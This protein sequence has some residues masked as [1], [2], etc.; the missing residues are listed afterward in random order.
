MDDYEAA[1]FAQIKNWKN[2]RKRLAEEMKKQELEEEKEHPQARKATEEEVKDKKQKESAQA[3]GSFLTPLTNAIGE[4]R[5]LVESL[6]VVS[7][8]RVEECKHMMTWGKYQTE[9]LGDVLLKLNLLIRKISDYEIRFGTQY[10]GFREKIKYLRTKDDTLCDMG[11]RQTDLQTK[12]VEVSKSRLRSAKA[13]L[14]QKELEK[15]QKESEPQESQLQFLKRKLIRDAYSEQLNAII[16]LGTKMQIIGEHG[17][18]LLE[19]IDLTC[20]GGEYKN[21]HETEDILQGARIALE[22]WEKLAKHNAQLTTTHTAPPVVILSEASTESP[23]V[24]AKTKINRDTAEVSSKAKAPPATTTT[25]T[26]AAAMTPANGP[27]LPPRSSDTPEKPKRFKDDANED[28]KRKNEKDD[29]NKEKT[30]KAKKKV[31]ETLSEDD[32]EWKRREELEI[33][34]AL[35]LSLVES[36][37]TVEGKTLDDLNLSAEELRFIMG[38]LESKE[39]AKTKAAKKPVDS[40][41]SSISSS[42][43]VKERR[44]EEEEDDDDDDDDDEED[45][46]HNLTAAKAAGTPRVIRG[47]Q[48][49]ESSGHVMSH[50]A[51]RPW[52]SVKKPK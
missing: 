30:G 36:S 47:P 33:R 49:S 26:T 35:E 43:E 46:G 5:R 13:L 48:M 34:K 24:A 17:K 27:P 23:A 3:A 29:N 45:L 21:D 39:A 37:T 38:E 16:E 12:I 41:S 28:E 18:Q 40:S 50:Q 52:F 15:I 1:I 42:T 51:P 20:T 7:K 14:L 8:V 44:W 10:E 9:D 31:E 2:E 11:R 4:Q 25:T 19:H 6:A 22:N 32:G